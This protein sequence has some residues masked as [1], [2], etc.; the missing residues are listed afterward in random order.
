MI[1]AEVDFLQLSEVPMESYERKWAIFEFEG[2]PF[3][4]RYFVFGDRSK[5]T[6]VLT[7]G[8]GSYVLQAFLMFK[9]LAEN[10]KVI[11]FD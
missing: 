5:P 9:D 1:E 4:A 3:K 2:Q 10:F 11:A 7:M 8:Y 6:L